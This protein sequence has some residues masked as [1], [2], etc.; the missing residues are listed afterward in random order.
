M[1]ASVSWVFWVTITLS[2][3]FWWYIQEVTADVQREDQKSAVQVHHHL[4]LQDKYI[5]EFDDN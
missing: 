1:S 4:L 5:S 3:F 2:S